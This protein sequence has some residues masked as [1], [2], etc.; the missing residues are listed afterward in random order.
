MV[1]GEE[2]ED[3]NL[4]KMRKELKRLSEDPSFVGLKDQIK[5]VQDFVNEPD[6]DFYKCKEFLGLLLDDQNEKLY[7]ERYQN[8]GSL[9]N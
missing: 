5:K 4:G 2:I 1:P 6:V 3:E 8:V 7:L 9:L